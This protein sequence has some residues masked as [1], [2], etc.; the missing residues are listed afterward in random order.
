M[1]V[2][3]ATEHAYS[4]AG[5]GRRPP[6]ISNGQLNS[7][8]LQPSSAQRRRPVAAAVLTQSRLSGG[9][10]TNVSPISPRLPHF[11]MRL[12]IQP[13]YSR[14]SV[15]LPCVG[16]W[17][18]LGRRKRPQHPLY[19]QKL[20]AILAG[21]SSAR[22]QFLKQCK[23]IGSRSLRDPQERLSNA[24]LRFRLRPLPHPT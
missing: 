14:P 13:C 9:T 2:A 18:L 17:P 8:P 12:A 19:L 24:L 15:G 5:K 4:R 20:G 1:R 3:M 21:K 10:R 16:T 6:L 11:A 7:P 22:F 23:L